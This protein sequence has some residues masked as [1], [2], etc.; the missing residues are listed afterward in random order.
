MKTNKVHEL[1]KEI[2]ALESQRQYLTSIISLCIAEA[3]LIDTQIE[4]YTRSGLLIESKLKDL[5]AEL[6]DTI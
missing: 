4:E 5:R 2:N 3:N 1:E 6:K